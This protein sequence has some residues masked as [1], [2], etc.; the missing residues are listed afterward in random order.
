M[1]NEQK[2]IVLGT[3]MAVLLLGV[4]VDRA[5]AAQTDWRPD[6]W[7]TTKAKIAL[8]TSEQASAFDVNVDTVDGRVTL[9]GTVDSEEAR[10]AAVETAREVDG[11]RAVDDLLQVVPPEQQAAV[12]K[13][14]EQLE[15]SIEEALDQNAKLEDSDVEVESVNAGVVLLGGEASDLQDQLAALRAAGA[16]PG[17]KRVESRIE[18]PDFVDASLKGRTERGDDDAKVD[19]DVEMDDAVAGAAGKVGDAA[20]NAGEA[21]QDAGA[22]V[23][24][25]ISDAWITTKVKSALIANEDVPA[26]RVNVDTTEGVVTLFGK[27]SS[28]E[29]KKT[30]QQ[31]AQG[32]E[33]V[34]K[35]ENLLQ[36]VPEQDSERVAVADDAIRDEIFRELKSRVRF[37]NA[38]IDV[39][40]SDGLVRLTGEAPNADLRASAATIARSVGG[41]RAVQNELDIES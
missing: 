5:G 36:V 25:A 38:D 24:S 16:V 17:V 41:V 29:E 12:E 11:V 32:V 20:K 39:E 31:D 10:K 3:A 1:F 37:S 26:M 4:G 7:I 40:V 18:G 34:A 14:D 30:A 2:R 9:H 19:D 23:A 13:A 8:A 15:A 33:G 27:V 35:V 28:E 21:T 22:A 6:A